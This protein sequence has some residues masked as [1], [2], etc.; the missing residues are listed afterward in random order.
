M[1]VDIP[2]AG[3]ALGIAVVAVLAVVVAEGF[4]LIA[5]PAQ[6][7]GGLKAQGTNF[8]KRLFMPSGN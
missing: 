2:P 8:F 4:G 5:P 1:K 3:K 7:I 6:F